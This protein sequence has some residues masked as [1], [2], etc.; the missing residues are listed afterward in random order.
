MKKKIKIWVTGHNG[1]LGRAICRKLKEIPNYNLLKVDKKNLDLKIYHNVDAWLKK[2]KPDGMIIA[3]AKVGGIY[4]NDNYP[5]DYLNDNL[6][7]QQNLI[8][9][10]YRHHVKKIV[11]IGSSCVYPKM[12]KQPIK[13]SYLLESQLEKTN[14]WYAIAKIA[15]IK[16]IQAY[17]KQYGA[18][19]ITIMPTNLYGPYDNFHPLDSHVIPGLIGKLVNAKNKNENFF[20]PWGTGK[21]KRD[22]LHVDDCADAIIKCYQKYNQ[23]EPI[24]I[25]S[26][27]EISIRQLVEEIANI[28]K[29]KGKIKFNSNKVGDG[30][31][32]KI[33]DISKISQLGWKPK[34]KLQ[35]GLKSTIKWYINSHL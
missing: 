6:L 30:T 5:V 26:G 12:S 4:A 29:F 17:R 10:G 9:L 14:Q 11:F 19:Y 32:R 13:E 25:G 21:A 15:G 1:M 31:P 24:N 35:S 28:I 23:S 22:F 16:L 7:I 20:K 2:N 18:N 27:G 33:L 8:N 3:S 34:I